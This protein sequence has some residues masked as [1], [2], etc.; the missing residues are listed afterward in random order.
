MESA[1]ILHQSTRCS[2]C[3]RISPIWHYTFSLEHFIEQSAQIV[4]DA[5]SF[6]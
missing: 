2:I 4:E 6:G 1:L 3:A 5:T